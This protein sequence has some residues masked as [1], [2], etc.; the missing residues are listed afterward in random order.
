MS[1]DIFDSEDQR[2]YWS[3]RYDEDRTGWDIGYPSTPLKNYIDQLTDKNLRILIP[4]AGNAYEAAYLFEQGFLNTVILDISPIPLEAFGNRYPKFPKDQLVNENFFS[5]QEQFDL[6][7]EQTFFCSMPPLPENRKAYAEQMSKLL[8]PGG[9][10][11][12]LWFDIPLTGDLVKRP[13]GGTKEEY[14]SYFEP[15]FSVKT[16]ATAHNSIPPRVGNELF[17]VFVKTAN[18]G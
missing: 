10:L 6:I 17:G 5:Y 3:A 8:K 4:G 11:V 14:L 16:F 9:K 7:I 2:S 13:F 15:Y 12:G 18:P 1:L